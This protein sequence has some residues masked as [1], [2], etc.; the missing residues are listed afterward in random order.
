[1]A[2]EI[3]ATSSACPVVKLAPGRAIGKTRTIIAS[4]RLVLR[5]SRDK[6]AALAAFRG[7][8]LNRD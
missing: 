5:E 1:M 4:Y 7:C 8:L 6:A 3:S 2:A